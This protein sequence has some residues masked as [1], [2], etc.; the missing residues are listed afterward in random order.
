MYD[1]E[2]IAEIL[3][4]LWTGVAAGCLL[5]LTRLLA[6]WLNPRVSDAL[7]RLQARMRARRAKV[8]QLSGIAVTSTVGTLEATVTRAP[9]PPPLTFSGLNPPPASPL[10]Q[11]VN[12]SGWQQWEAH[13]RQ[14]EIASRVAIYHTTG[15]MGRGGM[16]ISGTETVQVTTHGLP[17][18]VRS[19]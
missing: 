4:A 13:N 16:A 1:R 8:V 19:R 10:P 5:L 12:N 18:H 6:K 2:T 3:F 11:F 9:P 17:S 14:H 7:E 15:T